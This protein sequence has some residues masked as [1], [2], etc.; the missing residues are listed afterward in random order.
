MDQL[1]K[2]VHL[3]FQN[4][5]RQVRRRNLI[6]IY[7]DHADLSGNA[8]L[9]VGQVLSPMDPTFTLIIKGL[10]EEADSYLSRVLFHRNA[11]GSLSEQ[12]NRENGY[13]QGAPNLTWS[14]ASFITAKLRRDEA[15]SVGRAFLK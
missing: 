5:A 7:Y 9:K 15:I 4:E 10:F 11:D 2:T 13:M 8:Q 3:R 1:Q 14:H 6:V 12:M